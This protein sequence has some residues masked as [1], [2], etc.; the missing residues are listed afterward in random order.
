LTTVR[1][2]LVTFS[3]CLCVGAAVLAAGWGLQ[4]SAL[5]G[6]ERG[7]FAALRAMTKLERYRFVESSIRVDGAPAVSGR[8]LEGWYPTRG[9]LLRLSDGAGIVDLGR[10]GLSIDSGRRDDTV[11]DLLLGG[12]SHVLAPRIE[13]LIQNG[14]PT[15][16]ERAWF[17]RP[18]LAV[19]IRL[20][21]AQSITL[22]LAPKTDSVLGLAVRFAH[23]VASSRIH[24]L[25][26]TPARLRL[27]L[28]RR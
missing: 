18:A 2:L 4:A 16:A 23:V 11:A 12:C 21:H 22:Y 14:A 17:G 24:P 20:R 19:R 1:P 8:C 9:S 26:L 7:D 15:G 5:P 6:P 25:P 13:S 3:V 28:G 10:F 27:L